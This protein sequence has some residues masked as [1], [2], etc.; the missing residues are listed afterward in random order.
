M[1]STTRGLGAAILLGACLVAGACKKTPAAG[2]SD[3]GGASTALPPAPAGGP[4]GEVRGTVQFQGAPPERGTLNRGADPYCA[5]QPPAHTEEVVVN[6]NRTLRNVVV[7]V[8]DGVRFSYP[9]PERPAEIRQKSCIYVPRVQVAMSGQ[10]IHVY[11]DDQTLHN[12]HSFK[13]GDDWFNQPQLAGARQPIR[14]KIENG[15][16][17]TF[18]CDVH[19]WM[20]AYVFTRPHPFAAVTGD[21][22]SFHLKGLPPGTYTLEAWHEKYGTRAA[23]VTVE[24]NKPAQVSFSFGG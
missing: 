20:R 6:A 13:G 4:T 15:V 17:L 9:V 5:R 8:K 19:P 2:G 23:Q 14:K 7:S 12:V 1:R 22:G 11:N 3:G 10:E 18:R 24:P 21:D 16:L